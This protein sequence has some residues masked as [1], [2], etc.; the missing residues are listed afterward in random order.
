MLHG[1]S[2]RLLEQ[3]RAGV[4]KNQHLWCIF[5]CC[6]FQFN[7]S[8]DIFYIIHHYLRLNILVYFLS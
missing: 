4:L 3:K 6:E 8:L 2:Y 7:M 1:Q 5:N